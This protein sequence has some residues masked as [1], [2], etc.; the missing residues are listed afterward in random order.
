V[1]KTS[2]PA[3]PALKPLWRVLALL[4][5]GVNGV[6]IAWALVMFAREDKPPAGPN[7]AT[8]DTTPAA[9]GA[10][11]RGHAT[12]AYAALGS[13]TAENNRIPDLGWTE[14]QFAE[15]LEGMRSSYEGRGVPMDEDAKRLRDEI[16]ERVQ[17]M[18]EAERPDPA[19]EYF[20]MLREKEAVSRTPS[21]LHYR[22]T[23][24]GLGEM[25]TAADTVV[26][27][28]AGRLPDGRELP[29]FSRAR[30]RMAVRDLLPGLAEGVQL[31][32][33]GGKALVYVPASL[34]FGE[35]DWPADIP[36]GVPLAFFVELH[37]VIPAKS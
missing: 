1:K 10:K 26:I 18:I 37:E 29:A 2:A 15:F 11:A 27:S 8:Q 24:P 33:V 5:L 17:K 35:Q 32:R 23:E 7:V 36:K 13:F 12:G 6:L 14:A 19:E 28:F 4:S 9:T 21:G 25:A 34:S 3:S 30:V 22:I 16:G 20:R 31:L